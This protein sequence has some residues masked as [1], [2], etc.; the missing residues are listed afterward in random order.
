MTLAVGPAASD[1]APTAAITLNQTEFRAGDTLSVGLQV[2]NPSDSP[3]ANL[4]VGVVMPDRETAL[5]LA[6]GGMTLPVS[7]T[8]PANFRS[9]QPAPSGFTVNAP[10]FTQF[11]WPADGLPL[12][13]YQVFVALTQ[14]SNGNLLALDVKPL[15]YSPRN[16]F[17]PVFRK[18]FDG[19]FLYLGNWFDH[20]LPFEFVDMNGFTVNFAGELSPFGVDGHGGYDFRMPEGTPLCA[21]ADGTVT[22]AGA[23]TPFVCPALNNQVVSGLVVNVRH[24]APN[25]Q[26]I[27]SGYAHMSRVDVQVG[28]HVVAGQQLG[29]SGDTGCSTAPHLHFNTFRLDGTNNGQPT[30]IDPYGWDS[31]QAHPWAQ[32]PQGAQSF[33]L[34]LPGQAPALR[35]RP[36]TLAPNCGTPP[37]CG[38]GAVA[39]TQ[40]VYAG[41]RDDLNPNN[42]FVELTLDT[43]FNSGNTTRNLTG[44]RLENRAGETY[45][46]PAGFVIR[47]GQPVQI[48][49]GHGVNGEAV[50]FW[51]RDRGAWDNLV[52]CIQLVSPTGGRYRFTINGGC[53]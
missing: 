40:A 3:P 18:P 34:W 41:V 45:P 28:Q 29:L 23:E 6:P 15:T 50:L 42:E 39:I 36:V 35:Y 20:N 21:V 51:G 24:A 52:E 53:S 7:L 44:Y 8:D 2:T 1:A 25:A 12:G 30:R 48:Y 33:Y 22:F 4:Y 13:T 46:L 14:A 10:A 11:T 16:L 49:S 37:T 26:S 31:T 38:N 43:R 9:L 17:L 47:D 27:D 19:E 32:H 5:F